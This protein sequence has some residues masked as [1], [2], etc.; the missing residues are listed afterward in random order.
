ML[1]RQYYFLDRTKSIQELDELAEESGVTVDYLVTGKE[2]VIVDT[3]VD[4]I[5]RTE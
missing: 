3:E 1:I 4:P 5:V 2:G